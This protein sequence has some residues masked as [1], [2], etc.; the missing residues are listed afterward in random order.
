MKY[1]LDKG[2]HAVYNLRFHYVA[3]V[4]YRRKVLTPEI[5]GFLKQVNL[6]VAEK[7]GVQII[8]QETDWDHIH[9]L[10]AS[11]P[12]VQ[13]SKFINSLKS[14]SARLIFRKFPEVKKQLW[15]GH[16]WSPSYFMATVGEVKLEDVKRYVQSQG[17]QEL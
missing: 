7:F 1:N 8:E 2:C 13:L 10:F 16:F 9:I 3:C 5:S 12:Q 4:K 17:D 14:V 11:K 15:G 6:S